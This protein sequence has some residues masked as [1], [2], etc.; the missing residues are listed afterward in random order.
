MMG[1]VHLQMSAILESHLQQSLMVV[2]MES[3]GKGKRP[4]GQG[5]LNLECARDYVLVIESTHKVSLCCFRKYI[6]LATLHFGAS[7][8]L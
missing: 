7:L 4:V 2:R 6:L 5:S 8:S 1:V 3:G